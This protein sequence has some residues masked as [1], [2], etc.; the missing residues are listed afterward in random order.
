MPRPAPASAPEA[1]PALPTHAGRYVLDGGTYNRTDEDA[2]PPEAGITREPSP[3]P[4][5]LPPAA[6]DTAPTSAPASEA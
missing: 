2:A 1:P 6:A 3:V 5:A 4:L